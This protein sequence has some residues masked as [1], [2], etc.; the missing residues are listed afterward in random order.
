MRR[1]T[2]EAH[3]IAFGVSP[4]HRKNAPWFPS[5]PTIRIL[6]PRY[7]GPNP[8]SPCPS[9]SINFDGNGVMESD[10]PSPC[11]NQS[12]PQNEAAGAGA[13]VPRADTAVGLEL[14]TENLIETY[15]VVAEW[16]R[17]ADAKAAVVLT[18]G[19]AFGGLL[20]PT[21]KPFLAEGP[22]AHLTPWWMLLVIGLLAACLLL[23]GLSFFFA[24]LCLTPFRVKGRH[25]ATETCPHFHAVGIAGR[26]GLAQHTEFVEGYRHAKVD[27]FQK[28]VLAALL[29]DSHIS[30]AK[31]KAVSKSI[32]CVAFAALFG[33]AYLIAAQF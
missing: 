14:Q 26:Y 20:I 15:H 7:S 12:V 25:P 8:E 1:R 30:V 13:P 24:F 4:R 9:N 29:I 5:G 16:I 21:M 19:G 33:L 11:D 32:R 3:R 23:L 17:F 6:P 10:S 27:G 28:E 2:V 31:Y 22:E 18:V